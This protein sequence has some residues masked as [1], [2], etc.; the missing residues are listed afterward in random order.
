MV[1]IGNVFIILED[2][3]NNKTN[4]MKMFKKY[5]KKIVLNN[6]NRPAKFQITDII[7]KYANEIGISV[8]GYKL[9]ADADF[10]NN[11]LINNNYEYNE[12]NALD[13]R[14][15]FNK[16]IIKVHREGYGY[17][18]YINTEDYKVKI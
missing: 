10:I 15:I 11:G 4:I 14:L 13:F 6:L 17:F 9:F 12:D 7:F 3:K 2:S 1:R 8:G 16:N 5:G 18:N